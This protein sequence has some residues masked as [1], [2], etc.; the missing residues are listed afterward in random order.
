MPVSVKSVF[1]MTIEPLTAMPAYLNC[2]TALPVA[3]PSPAAMP[4]TCVPWPAGS[5]SVQVP[6]LICAWVHSL[7]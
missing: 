5:V 2:G 3:L 4:V 1:T 6:A 7:P